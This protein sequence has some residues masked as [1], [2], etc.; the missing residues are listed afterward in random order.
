MKKLIILLLTLAP[1]FVNAQT[2][3]AIQFRETVRL[4]IPVPEGSGLSE[5]QFRAMVPNEQVAGKI[6]YFDE[7]ASLYINLPSDAQ[8]DGDYTMNTGDGGQIRIRTVSANGENK[9]YHDIRQNTITDQRDFLGKTFLVMDK[10]KAYEWKL[11]GESKQVAG[12][13]C[14]KAT[15]TLDDRT[16]EAWFTSEIPI[17]SGPNNVM[18]LPGMVLEVHIFAE[19][20]E[21]HI[22]AENIAF[23]RLEAGTLTA[24]KKGKK[25][26][27]E[28]YDA[29]VKEKTEEMSE[30]GGMRIRIGN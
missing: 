27:E 6:L 16:I 20:S 24:P 22:V 23:K 9:I 25:V 2:E 8:S 5:E 3:G 7:S 10:A 19:N 18:N 1:F 28:E 26:T 15:A 17:T 4:D 11:T 29:I 30:G 12:H 13:T 21:R 14:Q